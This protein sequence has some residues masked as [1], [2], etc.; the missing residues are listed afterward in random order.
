MPH[1]DGFNQRA[2]DAW[3]GETPGHLQHDFD[4]IESRA[5][6][7]IPDRIRAAVEKCRSLDY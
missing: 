3:H 2:F 6:Q 5:A 7:T 4:F 1:S